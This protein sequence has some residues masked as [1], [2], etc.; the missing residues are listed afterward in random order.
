MP[1]RHTLN[2]CPSL[3]NNSFLLLR[4]FHR[5]ASKKLKYAYQAIVDFF[6]QH[7]LNVDFVSLGPGPTQAAH[8][9]TES[10]ST[11]QEELLT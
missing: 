5:D 11:Q 9:A 3:G 4:T 2:L 8:F 1:C 6:N 10:F 7:F